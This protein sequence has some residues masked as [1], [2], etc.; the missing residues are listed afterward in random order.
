MCNG[1]Y[2]TSGK[3]S[4][5]SQHV[6]RASDDATTARTLPRLENQE[7]NDFSNDE[8]SRSARLTLKAKWGLLSPSMN[9]SH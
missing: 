3:S 7:R 2:G 9:E 5:S 6:L 1:G 4:F 8:V